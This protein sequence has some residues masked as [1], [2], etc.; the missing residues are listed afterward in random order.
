M[1]YCRLM[2]ITGE[3]DWPR[4][5][6][7]ICL[8]WEEEDQAMIGEWGAWQGCEV[9]GSYIS[10]MVSSLWQLERVKNQHDTRYYTT[11]QWKMCNPSPQVCREMTYKHP[12]IQQ[13]PARQHCI[14]LSI[15]KRRPH[16]LDWPD[17]CHSLCGS[18]LICIFQQCQIH[19]PHCDCCSTLVS[20]TGLGLRLSCIL[21]GIELGINPDKNQQRREVGNRRGMYLD[22]WEEKLR[23]PLVF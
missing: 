3:M 14:Y 9:L 1:L 15:V 16:N 10:R 4:Q 17:C 2:R 11:P 7:Q 20:G 21:M 13:H 5:R 19:H 22:L 23:G 12:S 8:S 18:C 6:S